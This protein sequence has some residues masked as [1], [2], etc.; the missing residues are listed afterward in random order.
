MRRYLTL[1]RKGTQNGRS[2]RRVTGKHVRLAPE[3]WRT[4]R[5]RMRLRTPKGVL[6]HLWAG[7]RWYVCVRVDDFLLFFVK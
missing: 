4:K 7:R 6:V 2:L 1:V 5:H 3:T